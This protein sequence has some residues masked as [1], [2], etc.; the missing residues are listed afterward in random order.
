MPTARNKAASPKRALKT[1]RL[2][3]HFA[4]SAKRIIEEAMSVTG[5]AVVDLA[6]EGARRLLDEHQRMI[7]QGAD[8][9][10]FLAAVSREPKPTPALIE[11]LKRHVGQFG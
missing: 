9:E 4:P 10:V 6:V 11:A 7:L 2:E 1:R 8:R 3:L 5:L